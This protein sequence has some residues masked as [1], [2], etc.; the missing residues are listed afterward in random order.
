M[1]MEFKLQSH[2]VVGD[3]AESLNDIQKLYTRSFTALE[4]LPGEL[5]TGNFAGYDEILSHY[6]DISEIYTE[7]VQSYHSLLSNFH[8]FKA[9]S[10]T[11]IDVKAEFNKLPVNFHE[12]SSQLKSIIE[13]N[14]T[15]IDELEQ[16]L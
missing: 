8:Q 3:F 13:C 5:E 6:T 7:M 10:R 14:K 16:L 9:I 11:N 15:Y 2:R 1:L 12:V 4:K